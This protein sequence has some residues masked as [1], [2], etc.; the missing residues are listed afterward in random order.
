MAD[1]ANVNPDLE[2]KLQA[3]ATLLPNWDSYGGRPS[4]RLALDGARRFFD[5]AQVVPMSDGGI[6]L[7]WHLPGF[8]LEID[9][10]PDGSLV[11]DRRST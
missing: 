3:L 8:D 4:S 6:Q 2:R 11:V 5:G 1:E 7:E 9:V 10:A